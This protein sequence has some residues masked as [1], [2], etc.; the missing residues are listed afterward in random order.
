MTNQCGPG[1][2][3][4]RCEKRKNKA[5]GPHP[6]LACDRTPLWDLLEFFLPCKN[7]KHHRLVDHT[8][9]IKQL[10]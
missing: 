3:C 5:N 1:D 8:D 9:T 4:H 2:P 6:Q 7:A 10:N